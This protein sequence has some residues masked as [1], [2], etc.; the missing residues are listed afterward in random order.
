MSDINSYTDLR[1]GDII[2]VRNYLVLWNPISWIGALIRL[3]TGSPWNH[4]A[5]VVE[6]WGKKYIVESMAKGVTVR[7]VSVW[8]KSNWGRRSKTVMILRY[9]Y[10]FDYKKMNMIAFSKVGHT[11]YWFL[12]TL[13]FQAIYN[14]TRKWIGP[15]SEQKAG[16]KMYCSQFVAWVYD[17][18]FKNFP[19][20]YKTVPNDFTD[21][22]LEFDLIYYGKAKDLMN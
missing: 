6:I 15:K 8:A 1:S 18:M 7:P 13:F 20:W 22:S 12:G 19:N 9:A 14:V 4:A 5:M 3:F 2:V 10:S 16:K 17:K 11:K 21:R